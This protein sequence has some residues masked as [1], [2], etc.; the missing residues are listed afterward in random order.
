MESTFEILSKKIEAHDQA[1]VEEEEVK[2]EAK[3]EKIASKKK[4]CRKSVR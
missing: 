1:Q 4:R 3:E 2:K